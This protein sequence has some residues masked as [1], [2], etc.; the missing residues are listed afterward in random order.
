MKINIEKIKSYL[1]KPSYPIYIFNKVS[2][3]NSVVWNLIKRKKLGFLIIIASE[4]TKGKGQWGRDWY[5]L[6]GGL[7]ISIGFEL[8]IPVRNAS[9]ITLFSAWS[10][11]NKLRNYQLSVKLKW[12]ND[13]VIENQKLGGIKSEI[14]ILNNVITQV[15]I[16]IGIN[17]CNT[18]PDN[19]VN[20]QSHNHQIISIEQLAAI[21]IEA[22]ISGYQ[23]YLVSGIEVLLKNYIE[24]LND[25]GSK[26]I[27]NDSEKIISGVNSE[28]KLE[29]S[30]QFP[31]IMTIISLSSETKYLGYSSNF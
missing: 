31:K 15:V 19:G 1:K 21:I 17:W 27:I 12:P 23:Y 6:P 7:Y 30:S 2:S 26:I 22:I 18:V 11:A 8:K 16:G 29:V 3:T 14:K 5:S 20:I 4:Q 13:L 28:G 10:V 25:I 24:I 9:H